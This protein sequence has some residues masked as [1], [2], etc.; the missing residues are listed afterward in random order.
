MLQGINILGFFERKSD[1]R[2]ER[3]DIKDFI[4]TFKNTTMPSFIIMLESESNVATV[5]LVKVDKLTGY[6]TTIDIY[7]TIVTTSGLNKIIT[8]NGS[9]NNDFDYGY[10]YLL[11]TIGTKEIYSEVFAIVNDTYGLLGINIQSS[12]ITYNKTENLPYSNIEIDFYL[13]YDNIEIEHEGNEEGTERYFGDI[14]LFSAVS[15]KRKAEIYGTPQIYRMLAFTRVLKV[16]GSIKVTVNGDQREVYDTNV[17]V[18]E[19]NQASD[20]I[21][22]IFSYKE[23]DFA[24]SSNEI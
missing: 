16:N 12:D 23:F 11:I 15:I 24:A 4:V 19:Y 3:A 2:F 17:E 22:I 8:Y 1:R 14:P 5:S 21:I 7:D 6:E 20:T 10:Y 9:K 18:K 13:N